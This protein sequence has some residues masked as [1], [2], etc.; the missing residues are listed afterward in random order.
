VPHAARAPR[1]T[2]VADLAI[3]LGKAHALLAPRGR[4]VVVEWARERFD[5]TTARWCFGRLPEP[6]AGNPGWLHERQA[7]WAASGQ[8]WDACLRSWADA[9]GLHTGQAILD[10]LDARF[11]CQHISFGACFFADLSG[12][13]E[14]DEQA[15]IDAA[16]I[17]ANRINYVA[18]KGPSPP[19]S[20]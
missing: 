20:A 15:A 18:S 11:S 9:E 1:C 5:E 13:S 16:R 2:Y 19:V 4:I 17:R 10:A 7:E 6:E 14:A 8:S 3:V 12:T